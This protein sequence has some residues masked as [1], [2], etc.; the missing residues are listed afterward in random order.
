V[1][2]IVVLNGTSSS[3]K[4]SIARAFQEL[5]PGTFL[6]FSIDSILY[7]LPPSTLER[8]K[9]GE[10]RAGKELVR[11]FYACVRA[12]ADEGVDLVIDHALT[13]ESEATMLAAATQ[14]HRTL[15]VG[16][17]CP[18]DVLNERERQRGDR[19][20]GMA[21]AQAERVHQWL[22]YDLRV[23]SSRVSPEEAARQIVALLTSSGSRAR[24]I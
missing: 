3:G 8:M 5:A 7:A 18:V 17:D 19:R 10:E 12:I 14:S 4:T 6:N 11:A 22:E 13:T 2:R 20:V 15:L 23:D 24:S 9:R 1:S 21:A 16:I